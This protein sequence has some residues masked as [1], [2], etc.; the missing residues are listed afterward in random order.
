MRSACRILIGKHENKREFAYLDVSGMLV[1]KG[2]V[3][4]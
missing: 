4:K 3:N 1:L 2:I